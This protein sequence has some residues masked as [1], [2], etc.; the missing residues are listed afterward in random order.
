MVVSRIVCD[1]SSKT[2]LGP[3]CR[4]TLQLHGDVQIAERSAAQWQRPDSVATHQRRSLVVLALL[5]IDFGEDVNAV[6]G[7]LVNVT[8]RVPPTDHSPRQLQRP[9]K[10]SALEK[11]L[12]DA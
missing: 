1:C 7:F 9:Q 2:V 8:K 11:R 4:C 10:L 3:V 12:K 6:E 5:K